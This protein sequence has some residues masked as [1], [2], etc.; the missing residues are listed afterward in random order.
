MLKAT[1]ITLE[2]PTI[3]G[4]RGVP[5]LVGESVKPGKFD[6]DR[7][8]ELIQRCQNCGERGWSESVPFGYHAVDV[9]AQ[10]QRD[11]RLHVGKSDRLSDLVEFLDRTRACVE[12][13]CGPL[14]TSAVWVIAAASVSTMS[15]T[16]SFVP[17]HSST[18]AASVNW[19]SPIAQ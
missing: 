16:N 7:R 15:A 10:L 5:R 17:L 2:P 14:C 11:S 18:G 1:P 6:S 12:V 13:T 3:G 4:R 9:A 8:V 19:R